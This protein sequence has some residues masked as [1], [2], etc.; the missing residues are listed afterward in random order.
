MSTEPILDANCRIHRLICTY[1]DFTDRKLAENELR[2]SEER[3]RSLADS[4]PNLAWWANS[5]GYI[6]WY[7][8]RWYEYTGTTPEQMEGWGWQSVHD[9]D[10]LPKVLERWQASIATGKPFEMT[11][12][13]R[14]NDGVFRLF[15][16]RIIPMKD[17]AGRVQ[18]W[19]GTNTDVNELEQRVAERTKELA[20]TICHL[21]HEILEREIAQESLRKEIA[22]R[23]QATEALREKERLLI[24]Q[25]RHAAM[26]EM[27]G[28][29][30]HQWRQPLNALGLYTQSLGAFYGTPNFNK[31]FVDNSIAKSMGILKHLSKT[32]DDFRDYFKPEKEKT[33]F[34]V[35]EAIKSIL[36]LLEGN[37]QHPKITVDLVAHNNPVINGYRNEFTQVILNILNNARDA[38][39]ERKIADARVIITIGS[40]S[41]CVVVTVADNAGGIPD[42]D[43][44][45]IFDPYFTT[46]GPQI[47]T[48]IGLF[49]SKTI[50]AKNMGGRLSVRN[51]ESGAEFRIEVEHGAQN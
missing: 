31:E 26:G 30:A 50:I 14:G 24:L 20:A 51:T 7:N 29:I 40:E 43:I 2:E 39:I 12:P 11:F 18:Q 28:N 23:L 48:G 16:T 35:I 9:P 25:S 33:D 44:D 49:M 32:I 42:K 38:I 21:Q 22:I 37:F 6:T 27:I 4:I 41:S 45:K 34:Y 15:L 36:S 47:G 46:K 5:D 19:F 10:E 13:L 8:R 3:L 1:Y 17:A